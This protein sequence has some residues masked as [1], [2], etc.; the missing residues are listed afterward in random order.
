MTHFPARGLW[1]WLGLLM[2]VAHLGLIF[3]GLVPNLVARP[4][5]L[6]LIHI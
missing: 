5:H 4:L 6:S 2:I 3:Y 1:V